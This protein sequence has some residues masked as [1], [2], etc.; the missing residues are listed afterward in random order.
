MAM[1][2]CWISLSPAAA[3]MQLFPKGDC[4]TLPDFFFILNADNLPLP[5]L[6]PSFPRSTGGKNPFVGKLSESN[7]I[8]RH[9][10]ESVQKDDI[11]KDQE[12]I[13]GSST[14]P[15]DVTPDTKH[16]PWLCSLRT[17]GFRGRHRCGVT[18]LSGKRC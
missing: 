4:G 6:F 10:S 5:P 1:E 9:S 13:F 7:Q 3:E 8:L 12:K 15:V 18:L 17:R 2:I 16:H 14:F 11:R